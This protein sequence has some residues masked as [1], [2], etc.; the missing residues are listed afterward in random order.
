MYYTRVSL[1]Y[2][3]YETVLSL[4]HSDDQVFERYIYSPNEVPELPNMTLF[5]VFDCRWRLLTAHELI[6]PTLGYEFIVTILCHYKNNRKTVWRLHHPQRTPFVCIG[7]QEATRP[8]I[9]YPCVLLQFR[10]IL[11]AQKTQ[12]LNDYL[13]TLR[14]TV[15]PTND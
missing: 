15:V 12:P 7:H 2:P 10:D 9:Q 11:D 8:H 3:Q 13:N 14:Y 4:C 5:R 1:P 6:H